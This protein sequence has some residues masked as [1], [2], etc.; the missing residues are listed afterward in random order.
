MTKLE[1]VAA[2]AKEAEI[3]KVQADDVLTSL[4]SIIEED[5]LKSGS[6]ITIPGLG[7][8]KQK[9]VAARVG[10]NPATGESINISAKTSIT[11]KMAS[12]LKK[13]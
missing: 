11:F 12:S 10:R 2:L 7:T 6:T 1:L 8:F 13:K 3:T 4:A 5:V 9:N